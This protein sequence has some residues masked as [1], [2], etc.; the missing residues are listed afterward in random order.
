MKS[1][2]R[3]IIVVCIITLGIPALSVAFDIQLTQEQIK[4]ASNYGSKY[5][6]KEIFDSP[7]VKKACFGEYPHG[8]GGVIMS[9]YIHTAVMSAMMALK[10]KTVTPEDIQE[11]AESTTFKVVVAVPD[12]EIKTPEDVQIILVQGTN[13]ILPQKTEFGMKYKDKRQGIVGTFQSDKVDS[14]A[15]TTIIAKTRNDSKKYKIDFSDVK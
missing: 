2:T 13:N 11:I 12:E 10:D 14:K 6:G 15:N 3:Y 4:E 9:K 1:F 8:E 7:V 5:K